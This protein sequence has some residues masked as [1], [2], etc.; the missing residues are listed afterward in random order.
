MPTHFANPFFQS[1]SF[2]SAPLGL[3]HIISFTSKPRILLTLK[4]FGRRKTG[5]SLRK[6]ISFFVKSNRFFASSSQFQLNQLSSLSW[7]YVLLFPCCVRPNSSPALSIG[8]PCESIKV[9]M[10][11]RRCRLRSRLTSGSSVGPS[12]PQFQELLLLSPSRFS[13]PFAS[14]CLSL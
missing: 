11:F 13:S 12:A 6:R 14:L 1:C 5:C 9:A 3:N 2:I 10:K 4:Y 8:T 7:Q